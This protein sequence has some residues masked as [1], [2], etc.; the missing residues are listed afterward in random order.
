[1]GSLLVFDGKP[2][3][4]P[5]APTTLLGRGE[6]CHVRL[7][8]PRVP[9]HWIE[10]R[11]TGEAWAWRALAAEDAT[12]GPHTFLGSG[13]RSLGN[14]GRFPRV[15]LGESAWVELVDPSGPAAFV[16]D[17]VSDSPVPDDIV[18]R[19]LEWRDGGFV[20]LADEGEATQILGDGAVLAVV[21][22]DRGP[23]ALRVHAP[24]AIA[25]TQD[26]VV[27]LLAPELALDLDLPGLRA[28]IHQRQG[29]VTVRGECVRVLAVYLA[30]RRESSP[31][32][33]WLTPDAAWEAWVDLGG[34]PESSPDRLSWERGKLRSQLAR[35]R[36]ANVGA[37]FE[38]SR[39][40]DTVRTRLGVETR[41]L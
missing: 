32:G 6:A 33:G 24:S 3:V 19:H 20:R 8:H 29:A 9:L 40:G 22:R 5:L 10:V 30:A 26:S 36:V 35:L 38:L 1:M 14:A 21:D 16:W 23:L 12:R 28:T 7:H 41:E 39:D 2:R 31:N 4:V 34:N 17:L 37:L 25:A 11:W 15:S 18:A 27:D 13:W